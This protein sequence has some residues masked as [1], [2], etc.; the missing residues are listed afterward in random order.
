M[1]VLSW[2][3]M[4]ENPPPGSGD[5]ERGRPGRPSLGDELLTLV[6]ERAYTRAAEPFLLASGALSYDYVDMR[7]AVARGVDLQIA[8]R[9]VIDHLIR[10]G[11]DYD[12]IGGMTMGA[13]P[14]SHAV[15]LLAA[16]G[17]FSIR[18]DEKTHGNRRRLE[19]I[20]VAGCRVVL[21]EDTASTGGSILEAFDVAAGAGANVVHACVLFD[22]GDSAR[23]AFAARGVPYSS[24][25]DYRD[26]GIEPIVPPPA[27]E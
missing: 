10:V 25:L 18:K 2:G 9:A 1:F 19:G 20:D 8:A 11:V 23:A 7:R 22:R 5:V 6:R 3:P 4:A 27:G 16:K 12:A 15:A 21:F 17:W 14:V 13:D 24:L 26:L